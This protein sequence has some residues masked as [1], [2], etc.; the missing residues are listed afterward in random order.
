MAL[1]DIQKTGFVFKKAVASA[2]ET[3]TAK[4]FFEE[5]YPARDIVFPTQ[6]WNQSDQ[7]PANAP[8]LADG[9]TSGVVQYFAARSMT[10]IAGSNGRGYYLADLVNSIPF[11]FNTGYSPTLT[12]SANAAIAPGIGDWVVNPASGTLY[13]YGTLPQGVLATGA[14]P[15]KITFYKYIGTKGVGSGS[16]GAG[17][18][19]FKDEGTSLGSAQSVNFVGPTIQASL[20]DDQVTVTVTSSPQGTQGIQG[21]QGVGAQGAQGTPGT[22]VAQGSQGAQG[23]QGR[24]GTQGL[25]GIQGLFGPTGS[26]G[27]QGIQGISGEFVS[28]GIQGVQGPQGTGPQ[29]TQGAIGPQGAQ[30]RQGIQGLSQRSGVPWKYSSQISAPL[31]SHFGLIS[32][33]Q[34]SPGAAGLIYISYSDSVGQPQAGW[35]STWTQYSHIIIKTSSAGTN[36]YRITGVANITANSYYQFQ[37]TPLSSG[38]SFGSPLD[39]IYVE[40]YTTLQGLTGFQGTTG[41]GLQGSTGFQGPSA[42]PQGTQGIQGLGSPGPQG[43]QGIQGISGAFVSQGI[44]GIQGVQGR[45]GIQGITG[46]QGIQGFD[47]AILSTGHYYLFD[48][49]TTPGTSAF[50]RLRYNNATLASVTQIYINKSTYESVDL[51]NI[52]PN[53]TVIDSYVYVYQQ[54]YPINLP[55]SLNA[56]IWK[57]TGAINT[58]GSNDYITIPVTLIEAS[59]PVTNYTSN[60][61]ISVSFSTRGTQG[62]QGTS[63]AFVSQGIQGTQGAQGLQGRQGA[64]GGRGTHGGGGVSWNFSSSTNISNPGSGLFILNNSLPSSVTLIALSATDAG[65]VPRSSWISSWDDALGTSNRGTITITQSNILNPN[66]G[67][68][69]IVVYNVSGTITDNGTWFTIPV[70]LVSDGGNLTTDTVNHITRISFS[71]AGGQGAAGSQGTTGTQG[72]QGTGSQGTQGTSGTTQGIQ[73]IQGPSGNAGGSFVTNSLAIAYAIGLS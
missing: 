58:N 44:Q 64:Q 11:N 54:L 5:P 9:A 41:T 6:V 33:N 70:S 52:I 62:V 65:G 53:Y 28:Q 8:V 22:A 43:S 71:P 25:Q 38:G 15:P 48:S 69:I 20:L 17:S 24:Q 18:L 60:E 21:T 31:T 40:H 39:E 46:S 2:A 36:V 42:G 34:L 35:L 12:N 27:F 23:V 30:G 32:F 67:N 55:T 7:I 73:G 68:A 49:G 61:S 4:D 26:L 45:Q 10:H 59:T 14:N 16:G 13:F 57:V 19:T 51:S 72:T 37:V 63:G 56:H 3:N 1:S 47:G 29:G 66:P 50:G